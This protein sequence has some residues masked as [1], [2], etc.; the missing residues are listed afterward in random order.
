MF[1]E[2]L[3]VG[4]NKVPNSQGGIMWF[5]IGWLVDRGS[6]V[7][8]H[9]WWAAL[10]GSRRPA[11]VQ[12]CTWPRVSGPGCPVP[13]WSLR[14]DEQDTQA[15]ELDWGSV[16]SKNFHRSMFLLR[17]GTTWFLDDLCE[18]NSKLEDK[19]T[20]PYAIESCHD[21]NSA[22]R[23][24][25]N[26]IAKSGSRL[27]TV[28]MEVAILAVG[29]IATLYEMGSRWFS[30]LNGLT[31]RGHIFMFLHQ[32]RQGAII[33]I[34]KLISYFHFVSVKYTVLNHR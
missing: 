25:S 33:L 19:R 34:L 29:V 20:G 28:V 11:R 4:V 5:V 3:S 27:P 23:A 15:L 13:D 1:H 31:M 18:R 6:C 9:L 12:A 21:N 16:I 2:H 22:K 32:M 24:A 17:I 30:F 14:T 26:V 7:W 10:P 8:R